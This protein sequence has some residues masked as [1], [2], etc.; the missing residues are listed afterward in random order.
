MAHFRTR[1]EQGFTG[2]DQFR[3]RASDSLSETA[4]AVVTLRV[5]PQPVIISEFMAS[6]ADTVET[7]VRATSDDRFEGEVLS[8][9]WIELRNVLSVPLDLGGLYLTDDQRSP[10]KWQFPS[11]T[12]IAPERLSGRIRLGSRHPR[13]RAR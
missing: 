12:M 11:G 9:D 6:N 13:P 5:T 1:P 3:Y 8:P 10:E 4:E 2:V 7:Y